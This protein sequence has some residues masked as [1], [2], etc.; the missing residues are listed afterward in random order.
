MKKHVK[1]I[2]QKYGYMQWMP[3]AN[4][5]G[6]S[7]LSDIM[8]LKDGVFLAIETKFGKNK[9]TPMQTLFLQGIAKQ[10]GFAFVVNEDRLSLLDS[11]LGA[12]ARAQAAAAAGGQPSREDGAMMLNCIVAMQREIPPA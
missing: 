2:L 1:R 9:P 7:G 3:P 12:F 10:S 5:Y 8:A 11:W 4:A 6:K